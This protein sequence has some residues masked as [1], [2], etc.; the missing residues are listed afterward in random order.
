MITER[1]VGS[2]R[3]VTVFDSP[4]ANRTFS[5]ATSRLGGSFA[6]A[7]NPTCTSLI[8]APVR[9]PVFRI[10]DETFSMPA[11]NANRGSWFSASNHL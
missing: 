9:L 3:S 4:G 7:G 1:N 10:V 11:L 6:D 8:S 5:H 2:R